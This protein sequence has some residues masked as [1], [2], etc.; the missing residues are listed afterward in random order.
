MFSSQEVDIFKGFL[1]Q[2]APRLNGFVRQRV[3]H[4]IFIR[5][6]NF[7]FL[8]VELKSSEVM[9]SVSKVNYTCK[10]CACP[11]PLSRLVILHAFS[12]Q[13]PDLYLKGS[14]WIKELI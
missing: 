9:F 6:M 7:D 3:T 8:D 4:L 2:I 14:F 10:I 13:R 12:E 11:K 1:Q 5:L